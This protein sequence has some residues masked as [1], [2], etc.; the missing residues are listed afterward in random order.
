MARTGQTSEA[1]NAHAPQELSHFAFLIGSWQCAARLQSANGRWEELRAQWRGQFILDGYAIADEYRMMNG[2]GDLVVLGMNFRTF[3]PSSG[4]WT[5]KWLDAR[6]GIW[7]DLVSSDLGGVLISDQSIT[8]TF[9]EPSAGHLFTRASYIKLS[10][11]H[12]TWLG[13]KSNDRK[14]W[15]KFLIVECSRQE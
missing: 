10:R 6:N 1:I 8:Y 14:A 11:D 2:A 7:T 3:D 13:E 15:S 5:I 4:K 12:F 9:K